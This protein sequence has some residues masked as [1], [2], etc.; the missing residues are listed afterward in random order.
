MLS[1][2][3]VQN[4]PRMI[5]WVAI[6]WLWGHSM[7]FPSSVTP[8]SI[9]M[10]YFSLLSYSGFSFNLSLLMFFTYSFPRSP[11]KLPFY[12]KQS[13]N[14]VILVQTC[15]KTWPC[16][17]VCFESVYPGFLH[18][19]CCLWWLNQEWNYLYAVTCFRFFKNCLISQWLTIHSLYYCCFC[20]CWFI[21]ILKPLE[22][23]N[24]KKVQLSIS[25]WI[26][27]WLYVLKKILP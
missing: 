5:N 9:C 6:R 12:E 26:N 27:S 25:N 3:V 22:S 23:H 21:F 13:W 2:I 8:E 20:C 10:C 17:A 16:F 14:C 18:Y 4:L 24:K 15:S 1:Y 7:R 11:S 19:T